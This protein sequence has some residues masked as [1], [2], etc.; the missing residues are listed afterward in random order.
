MPSSSDDDDDDAV[1][2]SQYHDESS[3]EGSPSPPPLHH[4]YF[5]PPFYNRPPTPLPPSPSLTSLLRPSRPTTPDSSAD[6]LEPVPRASPR[7]QPTSTMASCF[8]SSP[9][10]PS[11]CTSSGPIYLR[12]FCTPWGYT[13]TRI[14][15]GRLHCRHSWSCYCSIETIIDD[16]ANV[17]TIDSKGRMRSSHKKRE[18]AALGEV[19]DW[20]GIWSH[21]TDA[22]MDVPLGGDPAERQAEDFYSR[23]AYYGT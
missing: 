15:G 17:A 2:H 8:I 7:S 5:A 23:K 21:G 20:K 9:H 13:T 16:A 19:K 10:S 11:S 18:K 6:E 22:V 14:A 3:S 1:F 4:N 12:H